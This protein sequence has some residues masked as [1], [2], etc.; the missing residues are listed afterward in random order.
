MKTD[1]NDI[2]MKRVLKTIFIVVVLCLLTGCSVTDNIYGKYVLSS[3]QSYIYPEGSLAIVLESDNRGYITVNDTLKYNLAYKETLCMGPWVIR[4][5]SRGLTFYQ[6]RYFVLRFD[7]NDSLK[8]SMDGFALHN[9]RSPLK[10]IQTQ[11]IALTDSNGN[12]LG[13]DRVL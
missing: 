7:D 12:H 10:R 5:R 6:Y 3:R 1:K 13:L 2:Y 11:S 4:L 9:M 8:I